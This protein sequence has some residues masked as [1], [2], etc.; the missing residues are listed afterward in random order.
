MKSEDGNFPDLGGHIKGEMGG[1]WMP[2]FKLM[3]GFWVKLLDNDTKSGTW[4]KEGKEFINYPYGNRSVY[5]PVLNGIEAERFQFCPQ[6]KEG[7][8]IE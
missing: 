3:D 2:R 8:V 5:A 7:I 6:G 4:L 1:L